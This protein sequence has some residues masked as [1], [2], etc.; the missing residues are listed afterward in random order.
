MHFGVCIHSPGLTTSEFS[1]TRY[2]KT[3]IFF[4]KK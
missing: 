3:K 4:D 2:F 1:D